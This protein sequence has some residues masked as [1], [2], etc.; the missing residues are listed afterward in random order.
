[1]PPITTAVM[2]SRLASTMALG[3]AVP[4]RPIRIQ[5]RDAVDQ[6]GDHVDAEQHP[7]DPDTGQPGAFGVIADGVNMAAPAV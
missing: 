6:P 2:V 4:A 3:L 5:A 7:V 1:M